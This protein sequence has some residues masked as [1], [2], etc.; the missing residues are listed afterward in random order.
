MLV[1]MLIVRDPGEHPAESRPGSIGRDV[2]GGL[3][4]MGRSEVISAV[5]VFAALWAVLSHN[6]TIVTI[7]AEDVLDAGPEGLGLLLSAA[8][9]GQLAGSLALVAYGEV[10]RK[11]L[12]LSGLS[13][14]YVL[15][16]TGFSLSSWLW[17]S[18]AFIFLGGVS[19]AVFSA[20]RH[21]M[22][23]RAAPDDMRGRVM[24]A[25][26]LVTRGLSPLSQTVTGL[27]VGLLGPVIALLL[28]TAAIAVATVGV[29]AARPT[30]WR[31]GVSDE[32]RVAQP[33]GG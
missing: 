33:V 30:L 26:L 8:N 18:A 9:L 5:M 10:H 20:T 1:A 17:G 2:F 28:A 4:F 7:F 24:G 14:L 11:G 27:S 31:Y 3:R 29:M 21:A 22:L 6:V 32:L 15:A 16:M 25:H 12:L 23:Q 19:H 13:A